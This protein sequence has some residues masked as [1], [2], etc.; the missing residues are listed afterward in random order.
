MNILITGGLGFIGSHT[1]VELIEKGHNCIIV[2]NL[3]NSKIEVLDSIEKITNVRPKFYQFNL[4]VMSDLRKVFEENE[5]DGV[6]HFAA[7]KSVNE[8]ISKSLEY[9]ENNIVGSIN[10]LKCMQ[11]YNVTNF[12]LVH[13]LVYMES[14]KKIQ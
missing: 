7:L 10:L 2:D 14:Q 6:I 12:V 3:I 11:E 4:L 9:Y 8:S 5:I 13:R 1:V